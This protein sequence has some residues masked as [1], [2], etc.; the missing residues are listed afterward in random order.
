MPINKNIDKTKNLATFKMTGI[1][2]FDDFKKVITDYNNEEPLENTLFDLRE[3]EG[4]GTQYS[5]EKIIQ[6]MD[7]AELSRPGLEKGRTALV[8]SKDVH[9]GICKIVEAYTYSRKIEYRVFRKME[10]AL[11]W[12]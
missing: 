4:S 11:E 5:Y 2:S 6:L 3:A 7:F 1:I 8:V 9:Y 10:E 12:L